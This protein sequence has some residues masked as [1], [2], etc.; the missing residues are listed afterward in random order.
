MTVGKSLNFSG[1]HFP[2]L[3]NEDFGP[4]PKSPYGSQILQVNDIHELTVHNADPL[5]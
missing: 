4:N 5:P 2:H 3:S 1:L